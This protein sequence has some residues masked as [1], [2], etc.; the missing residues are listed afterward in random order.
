MQLKV[1]VEAGDNSELVT[2]LVAQLKTALQALPIKFTETTKSPAERY[3]Q[4]LVSDQTVTIASYTSTQD[5]M[6]LIP[7]GYCCLL[8]PERKYAAL[9]PVYYRNYCRLVLR[10]LP[11]GSSYIQQL[12]LLFDSGVDIPSLARALDLTPVALEALAAG[13][14]PYPY[15]K[16]AWSRVFEV[17]TTLEKFPVQPAIPPPPPAPKPK[18]VTPVKEAKES[19][20]KPKRWRKATNRADEVRGFLKQH[21]GLATESEV[22]RALL[23]NGFRYPDLTLAFGILRP[24]LERCANGYGSPKLVK[25]LIEDYGYPLSEQRLRKASWGDAV[26]K[27]QK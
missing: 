6:D 1:I 13:S 19:N 27:K 18:T 26:S 5:P 14:E 24:S 17:S 2:A 21:T 15:V 3:L 11:A 9:R 10:T 8:L 4:T 12:N 22:V 7:L 20:A 16:A 25:C 23:Q